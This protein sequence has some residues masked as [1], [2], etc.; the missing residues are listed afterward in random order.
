MSLAALFWFKATASNIFASILNKSTFKSSDK[1]VWRGFIR[2]WKRT[3]LSRSATRAFT[4]AY[5][6]ISGLFRSAIAS[7]L[8]WKLRI[9]GLH[10]EVIYG[11]VIPRRIMEVL[12]MITL[13]LFWAPPCYC[14]RLLVPT[15]FDLY[16]SANREKSFRSKASSKI[17]YSVYQRRGRRKYCPSCSFL[18]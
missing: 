11:G 13:T 17:M 12:F 16:S 4:S 8:I 6:S 18:L 10:K 3:M 15:L 1:A 9:T 14:W 7:L 5:W 2:S